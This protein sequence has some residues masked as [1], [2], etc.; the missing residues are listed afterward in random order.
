[1]FLEMCFCS[2]YYGGE[3]CMYQEKNASK[4]NAEKWPTYETHAKA[5]KGYSQE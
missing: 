5:R 4:L 2:F 1:M 3:S